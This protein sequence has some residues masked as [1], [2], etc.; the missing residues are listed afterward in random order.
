[1]T[2]TPM[3]IVAAAR[4]RHTTKAY[5]ATRR[6]PEAEIDKLKALLQLSPSSTNIQ[7]WHFIVASTDAGKARVAKAA[8]GR[9]QFNQKNILDAS[10]VF[11]FASR[12]AAEEEYLLHVL[13]QEERDGRFA[14]DPDTHKPAMHNGRSMFLNIHKQDYK[15]AQHWLDKQVYL[16]IGQFLLGVAALGL[17][18]TPMEGIDVGVLDSEFS[19]REKGYSA[20]VVIPVGYSDAELDYNAHLP[21]SRLP[22]SD[23][24]EEV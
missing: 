20:L 8:E 5:D 7:P 12:L 16:N 22:L 2:D 17:D 14:T 9:F 3:D 15:D 4:A 6:V 24:L 18:A 13:A 10:H 21:K 1:M 23:I 11:V 19:L